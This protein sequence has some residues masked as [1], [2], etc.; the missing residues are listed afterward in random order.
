MDINE[1]ENI[2]GNDNISIDNF[3]ENKKDNIFKS[4]KSEN[5]NLTDNFFKEPDEGINKFSKNVFNDISKSE[6]NFV[7]DDKINSIENFEENEN[8]K[9]PLKERLKK[10]K[11]LKED[12][13]TNNKVRLENKKA[14]KRKFMYPKEDNMEFEEEEMDLRQKKEGGFNKFK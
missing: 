6:I 14:K 11:K 2:N 10:R 4:D 9:L 8:M 5:E 7:L 3:E 1:S 13:K 12:D